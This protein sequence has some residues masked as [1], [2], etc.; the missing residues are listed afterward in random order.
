MNNLIE[1]IVH[2]Y[3]VVLR[4]E[5]SSTTAVGSMKANRSYYSGALCECVRVPPLCYKLY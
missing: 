4:K 1:G 5:M 3:Y 2:M